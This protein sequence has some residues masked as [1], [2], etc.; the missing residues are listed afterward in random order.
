[1][2]GLYEQ[3]LERSSAGTQ[4]GSYARA[5]LNGVSGNAEDRVDVLYRFVKAKVRYVAVER[6][7]GWYL[8][9]SPPTVLTR[10]WGDCKE[11]ALLLVKLLEEVGIE[12]YVALV[13]S[14]PAELGEQVDP[15]FPRLSAFNH[16][17]V[18]VAEESIQSGG[19][20]GWVF[21]DPTLDAT[22][23]RALDPVLVGRSALVMR[24]S[25]RSSLERVRTRGAILNLP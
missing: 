15:A 6:G 23:D 17:I 18:A 10:G 16:A 22:N 24:D 1:L 11:K 4:T 9:A 13:D 5:L 20:G 8:P 2:G 19:E 12:A 21:L 7:V 25:G 14:A 3:Q